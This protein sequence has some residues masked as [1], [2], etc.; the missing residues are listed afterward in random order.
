MEI[1]EYMRERNKLYCGI[2][3]KFKKDNEEQ[4]KVYNK[5]KEQGNITQYISNLILND[6]HEEPTNE[7]ILQILEK[8][9]KNQ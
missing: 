4:M 2:S 5:L 1:K 3:L 9:L 8:R 7:Q 6:I